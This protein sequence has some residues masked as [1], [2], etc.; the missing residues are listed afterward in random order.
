MGGAHR[1]GGAGCAQCALQTN[2]QTNTLTDQRGQTSK[3]AVT[4]A[5]SSEG[6][7]PL[8]A[9]TPSWT[10]HVAVRTATEPSGQKHFCNE[11][12]PTTIRRRFVRPVWNRVHLCLEVYQSAVMAL[13]TE[14]CKVK[15]ALIPR[16]QVLATTTHAK[17][18]SKLAVMKVWLMV[19][20][21]SYL[22]ARRKNPGT[23]RA[24][25]SC[26]PV[27]IGTHVRRADGPLCGG[28]PLLTTHKLSSDH[29]PL[30]ACQSCPTLRGNSHLDNTWINY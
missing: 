19:V 22:A 18:C 14:K 10:L 17:G 26:P 24:Q 8:G 27:V 23:L 29:L 28:C 12:P 21:L 1:R 4:G 3:V 25:R 7:A 11:H 15:H 5:S 30:E 6:A 20:S 13:W 2:K 16:S 9:T